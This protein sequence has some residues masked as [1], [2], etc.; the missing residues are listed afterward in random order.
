MTDEELGKDWFSNHVAKVSEAEC[1]LGKVTV[2][3]WAEPG[4]FIFRVVYV[5]LRHS[6]I[7]YGDIGEAV[8][9][10]SGN[11]GLE[12]LSN[13]NIDYFAS[14]CEASEYGRGGREWS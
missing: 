12:F 1:H 10:W 5:I 2:L 6:L 9:Q 14:K 4:T 8:Y 7:V 3:E 13:L 11:I